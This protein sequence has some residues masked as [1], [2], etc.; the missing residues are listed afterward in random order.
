MSKS[1]VLQVDDDGVLRLP[2]ELLEGLGWDVGDVLHWS[3][4]KD[5]SVSV[6]RCTEITHMD[7]HLWFDDY[8]ERLEEEPVVIAD[9][10]GKYLLAPVDVV[11]SSL[12]QVTSEPT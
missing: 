3:S 11:F 1:Y 10:T 7:L 5:G 2:E 9:E 6:K 8:W 12:S 4:K